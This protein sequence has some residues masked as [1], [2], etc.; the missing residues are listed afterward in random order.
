MSPDC[1]RT[2][3]FFR[4]ESQALKAYPE[5]YSAEQPTMFTATT[6]SSRVSMA[7][8]AAALPVPLVAYLLKTARYPLRPAAET[9]FAPR[10]GYAVAVRPA[11]LS[12]VTVV[13]MVAIANRGCTALFHKVVTSVAR[14]M[15]AF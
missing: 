4:M 6:V 2:G 8:L 7:Q 10:R 11:P 15:D 14:K 1:I 3:V 5:T 9:I 13:M 12:I